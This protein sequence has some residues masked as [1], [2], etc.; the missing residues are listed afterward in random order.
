[1]FLTSVTGEGLPGN[2]VLALHLLENTQT[3][4]RVIFPGLVCPTSLPH[5]LRL[6]QDPF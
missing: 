1:M 6:D 2:P 5:A 4:L 3:P